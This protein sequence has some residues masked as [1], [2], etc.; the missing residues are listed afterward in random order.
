MPKETKDQIVAFR[1]PSAKHQRLEDAL[2][3]AN[4]PGVDSANKMARKILLDY[5]DGKMVYL[6]PRDSK[7]Q[8]SG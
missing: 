6:N 1:V 4:V 2:E 5:L 3:T 8:P 7:R